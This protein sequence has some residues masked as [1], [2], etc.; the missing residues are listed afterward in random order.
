MLTRHVMSGGATMACYTLM[1]K[2]YP[3]LEFEYDLKSRVV[4]RIVRMVDAARALL[5]L[6]DERGRT[7]KR[8][9]NY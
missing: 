5:G 7:S 4:T 3:V 9:L 6:I 1:N 8:D 2:D